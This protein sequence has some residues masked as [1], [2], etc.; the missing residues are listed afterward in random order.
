MIN[1]LFNTTIGLAMHSPGKFGIKLSVVGK[2][3]NTFTWPRSIS[4]SIDPNDSCSATRLKNSVS[5]RTLKRTAPEALSVV[6]KR[7]QLCEQMRRSH[8]RAEVREHAHCVELL[9]LVLGMLMRVVHGLV[10]RPELLRRIVEYATVF[11]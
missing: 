1:G 3:G 5:A 9:S 7:E 6:P 2:Y 8:P 4:D 11:V 10:D